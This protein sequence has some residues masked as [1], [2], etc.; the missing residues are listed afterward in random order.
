MMIDED[1]ACLSESAVYH[2]LSDHGL[3]YGWAKPDGEATQKEYQ[4]KPRYPHEHWHTDIAYIKI[5]G[6]FYF[7]IMALD[8]YSRFLLGW[9]LM[10]DMLGSS[11]ENFIAS[12]KEKYPHAKPK[13]IH[14]NGGQFVSHD[15]K[16]LMTSLEIQSVHTRRNHPQTN[17]KMERMNGTVKS[18]A[19]RPGAPGQYQEAW[20]ILNEY[21]Y[22]YNHQR[23]HAGIDFLRPS[24]LFFGRREKVLSERSH[25]IKHARFVRRELNRNAA[26]HGASSLN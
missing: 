15:F 22:T 16:K 12:V 25:K 18:E 23:L 1:V 3:L 4:H 5:A 21:G 7:L 8:G 17:G 9:E 19:I 6:V 13:L 26:V 11:V 14:D 10:T 20:E 2:I 24:D